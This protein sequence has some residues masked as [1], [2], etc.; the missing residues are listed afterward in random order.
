[1]GTTEITPTP[2]PSYR[3]A[4]IQTNP[5]FGD[6]AGNVRETL[7]RIE[8]AADRGALLMVLP[9]LCN[10]GYVYSSREEAFALAET[11]PDGESV[12]AWAKAAKQRNVYIAAG[13]TERDGGDLFNSAVLIGPEGHIGSFR[14][15]HLWDEEK[16]YFEPGNLGMPVYRTPIGR[17]GMLICFDGWFPELY[18][19]AAMQG[20]DIIC[21]C[22]NWVPMKNQPDD[23]MAMSNILA[24]GNAHCNGLNVICADRCG[25]ERGQPFIGQSLIV[26]P[27][28]WILAGPASKDKK[29]ILYA[30]IN[31]K[32]TRSSRQWSSLTHILRDRRGDV[33]DPL[34]GSG[35]PLAGWQ[36]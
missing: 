31:I 15:V 20:A 23:Q 1:M 21:V 12:K 30:D 29:E 7:L 2:F 25:V 6:K 9:E 33:Y 14:K 16:L 10:T 34:L 19:L 22:T 36:F 28:G 5:A 35:L 32:E 4:A 8:E 17:I 24:M 13:I 3:V 18:R 27:R 26:G 11:V